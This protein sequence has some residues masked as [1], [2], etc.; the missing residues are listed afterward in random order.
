MNVICCWRACRFMWVCMCMCVCVWGGGG[1]CVR[2]KVPQHT[3]PRPCSNKCC[4][5]LV[6]SP[7]CRP[8]CRRHCAI[9]FLKCILTI[10]NFC[11]IVECL[12]AMYKHWYPISA[13]ASCMSTDHL[14]Y[15]LAWL[16]SVY[17]LF[18]WGSQYQRTLEPACLTLSLSGHSNAITLR[19]AF[20]WHN[21]AWFVN[22]WRIFSC[23]QHWST[24]VD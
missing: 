17:T 22:A 4:V 7:L 21:S 3:T 11:G 1:G 19:K 16:F 14:L 13:G 6:S 2:E 15:Q 5:A 24:H 10:V 8:T 9:F 23:T 20:N 18:V 12:V